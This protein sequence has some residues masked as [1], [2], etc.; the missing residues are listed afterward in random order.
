MTLR[1]GILVVAHAAPTVDRAR[2]LNDLEEK[3]KEALKA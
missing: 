1:W 3:L 2:L